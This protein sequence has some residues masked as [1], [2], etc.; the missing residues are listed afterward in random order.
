[1]LSSKGHNIDQTR[2]KDT[3]ELITYLSSDMRAHT[4]N[5]K[6]SLGQMQ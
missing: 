3:N 2:W 1:V 4:H 6:H 5:I